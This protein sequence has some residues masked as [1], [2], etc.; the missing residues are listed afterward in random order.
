MKKYKEQYLQTFCTK[1]DYWF[2]GIIYIKKNK[3]IGV[4]K[5]ENNIKRRNH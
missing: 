4:R 2:F 5:Y 3:K 1:L